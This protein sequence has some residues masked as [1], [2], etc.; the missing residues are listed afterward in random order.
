MARPGSKNLIGRE[1]GNQ[2]QHW[3]DFIKSRRYYQ[4]TRLWDGGSPS[5]KPGTKWFTWLGFKDGKEQWGS[6]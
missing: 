3:Y 1:G 6:A 5:T 4:R 2:C